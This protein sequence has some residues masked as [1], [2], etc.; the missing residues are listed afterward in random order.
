MALPVLKCPFLSKFTVQQ[1]RASAPYIFNTGVESCP[2]FS[3]FARKIS[4]SNVQETNSAPSMSF[5]EIKAVH[6]RLYERSHSSSTGI[7]MN[8]TLPR[9]QSGF[10][11]KIPSPY[12]EGKDRILN[13]IRGNR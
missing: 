12:G 10:E 7:N 11:S 13:K 2:I 3:Q 5:D 6:E 8:M 9:M 4:T 1:V